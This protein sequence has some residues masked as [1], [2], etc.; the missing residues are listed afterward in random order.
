MLQSR[1]VSVAICGEDQ[2]RLDFSALLASTTAAMELLC[3]PSL[4]P[5]SMS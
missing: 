2:Q 5:V 3:L 4:L 1:L